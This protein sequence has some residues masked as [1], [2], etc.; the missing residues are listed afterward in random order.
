[1]VIK[2]VSAP[3]TLDLLTGTSPTA[4]AIS[5][6]NRQVLQSSSA[7]VSDMRNRRPN[8][9]QHD[10]GERVSIIQCQAASVLNMQ[11]KLSNSSYP[12]IILSI[13]GQFKQH[14]TGKCRGG[15]DVPLAFIAIVAVRCEIW[16]YSFTLLVPVRACF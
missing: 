7:N 8:S 11:N 3:S 14:I 16:E 15:R 9:N 2:T 5:A 13:C 12:L 10:S 6:V 4:S 1:M